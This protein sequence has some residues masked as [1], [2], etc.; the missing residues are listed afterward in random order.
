MSQPSSL[1]PK[2]YLSPVQLAV[3]AQQSSQRF[4]FIG[5]FHGMAPMA[6]AI[7]EAVVKS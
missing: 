1:N 3:A 2:I 6:R 7:A 5:V 4:A